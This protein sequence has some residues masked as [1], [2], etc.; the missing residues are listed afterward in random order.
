MNRTLFHLQRLTRSKAGDSQGR[1]SVLKRFVLP[2]FAVF[3]AKC[4][5][6]TGFCQLRLAETPPTANLSSDEIAEN[7]RQFRETT[8]R[9]RENLRQGPS[10]PP[11]VPRNA[12]PPIRQRFSDQTAVPTAPDSGAP[13]QPDE[14]GLKDIVQR[15]ELLKRLREQASEDSTSQ[16]AA[17]TPTAQDGSTNNPSEAPSG[18][19]P[20]NGQLRLQ[21][22]P[23]PL[24]SDRMGMS[25]LAQDGQA[26]QRYVS[27]VSPDQSGNAGQELPPNPVMYQ[28]EQVVEKPVDYLRLTESLFRAKDYS[29]ALQAVDSLE[30]ESLS[31]KDRVWA[32]VLRGLIYRR[33]GE[34]DKAQGDFRNVTNYN[35]KD[36][37]ISVAQFWLNQTNFFNDTQPLVN[38]LEADIETLVER[39]RTSDQ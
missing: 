26:S 39:A 37:M 16:S 11:V 17:S 19:N 34:I 1:R 20:G 12:Q 36:P 29:A 23:P 30:L 28:A 31:T 4:M 6:A 25:T 27:T 33:L 22:Q 3:L 15:I 32:D 5:P 24:P 18:V 38:Q 10:V 13:E 7:L 21:N 14:G 9:I 35:T 2:L 8:D